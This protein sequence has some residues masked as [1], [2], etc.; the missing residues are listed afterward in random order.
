M[1]RTLQ[2]R[3]L[4]P[5]NLNLIDSMV[6]KSN[7]YLESAYN[8]H[9]GI[10]VTILLASKVLFTYIMKKVTIIYLPLGFQTLSPLHVVAVM[11]EVLY[12]WLHWSLQ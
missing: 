4:W 3:A 9:A 6:F 5:S 2:P 11:S 10:H 8:L 12:Y 7:Y 1:V